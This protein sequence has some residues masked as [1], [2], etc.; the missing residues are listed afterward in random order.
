MHR[1]RAGL[2]FDE[3]M[4]EIGSTVIHPV[5]GAGVIRD[6]VRQKTDGKVREYYVFGVPGSSV[7]V[8][9][10]VETSS[11]VGLRPVI[12]AEEAKTI[13][14]EFPYMQEPAEENW[15][16]RYRENALRIKSGD[17]R[18]VGRVIHSLMVRDRVRPL[19]NGERQ[20]LAAAKQI[21]LSELEVSLNVPA[22]QLEAELQ[23]A[24]ADTE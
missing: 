10:P 7:T 6:I 3:D 9:V 11:A 13:L 23:R 1:N 5:H 19:S 12:D 24:S 18:E 14:A 15:N 4:F 20:M 21:F 16:K 2:S 17:P 8:M 22:A